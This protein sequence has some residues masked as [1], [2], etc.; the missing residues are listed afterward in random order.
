[1]GTIKHVFV[2]MLENRSFDHMLGFAGLTGIDA[3][4]GQATRADDL[5]SNPHFNVDPAD[6]AVQ[7]LAATPAE[8]KIS[9]PDCDPGHEFKNALIQLCGVNA[10]YPDPTTR[11]YPPIDNSGFIASYRVSGAPNPAKI[12]K[13]FSPEQVP[14][15]TTLAREF[16]VCDRWFASIPG[17]TWPNRFFIHAASSGGLDD[18]PSGFSSATSTFLHGYSF[19]NGT[20]YDRLDAK[21]LAWTVFMGD[22]LPQV[23]AIHGMHEAI[24]EGHF[25]NFDHFDKVVNDPNFSTPYVFI[26][27]SYGNILPLTPGD[28]TCGNSQHPLDDVTRGEKLIR[29]VYETIRNSPH[30]NNSLLLVTYDEHG[31]FYDHV[32]PPAVASPGD[33]ITD[34]DNNHHNFDFSQLGIRVPAIAVSPLIPRGT[35]DHTVYD[36]SSALATVESIFGIDPLTNRDR[37]ASSLNHLLSLTTPRA[38]APTGLPDPPDSGFRCEDDAEGKLAAPALAVQAGRGPAKPG[39][40]E[41]TLRA[42]AHIAFLRH[43]QLT[44]EA[45]REA[46]VRDFL[47][48]N[49]RADA[50]KY[51]KEVNARIQKLK[52]ETSK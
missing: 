51:M 9:P 8:F 30:W 4:T 36:H 6:P 25:K 29:K 45:D 44:P 21:R 18:S 12:M 42:W 33:Q 1:M 31:G 27:P 17:P 5:V 23:F 10:S 13:C 3:V 43:K 20:I 52:K 14:V 22:E 15:L 26:E 2:L 38:D 16:A 39:P 49:D 11:K 50:L 19:Q 7:V 35:I 24:L 41:P 28:F 46:L 47:K 34:D 48:I 40:I 37:Q 32:A